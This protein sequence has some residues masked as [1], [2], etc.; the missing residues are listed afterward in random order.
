MLIRI[1]GAPTDIDQKTLAKRADQLLSILGRSNGEL[2]ILLTD[3]EAISRLNRDY[4]GRSGPT[5]VLSFAPGES[6][7]IGL[8]ILGDIAISYETAA[9]QADDREVSLLDELTILLVH[10]LLHLLGHIHDSRE[11]ASDTD[12][13]LMESEEARLLNLFNISL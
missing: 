9:R 5:N 11:G 8:D 3:D 1:E 10:G 2:S 7:F 6:P 13:T 12:R 4:L